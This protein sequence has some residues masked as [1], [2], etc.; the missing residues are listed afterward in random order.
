[1]DTGDPIIVHCP[2]CGH[3][4]AFPADYVAEHAG[5]VMDCACGGAVPVP[6]PTSDAVSMT[7]VEPHVRGVWRD[8]GRVVVA[9]GTRM[10]DRCQVCGRG[11]ATAAA[12]RTLRW[13]PP[14]YRR[15]VPRTA[16]GAAVRVVSTAYE[17]DHWRQAIVRVGRC[18]RHPVLFRPMKA[19]LLLAVV[20][21]AAILYT[22]VLATTAERV[23]IG[24]AA[25]VAGALL[26]AVAAMVPERVRI[27]DYRGPYAWVR[28]Y[29]RGY[30]DALPELPRGEPPV[31]GSDG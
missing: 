21:A 17:D 31:P 29:G 8:G 26:S 19:C 24:K 14:Q 23:A 22:V 27:V 18:R 6:E 12:P 5:S 25:V 16:L 13:L 11:L 3:E 1:M 28:G 7:P 20:T 15:A 10:P 2:L 9:R 30:L 4:Y